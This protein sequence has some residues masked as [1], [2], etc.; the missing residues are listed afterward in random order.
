MAPSREGQMM[1]AD[2]GA[3]VERDRLVRHLDPP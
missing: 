2:V 3:S 1:K